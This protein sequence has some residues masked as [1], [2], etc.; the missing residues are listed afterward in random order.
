MAWLFEDLYWLLSTLISLYITLIVIWVVASWLLLF[1]VINPRNFQ[2]RNFIDIL[3]R[4]INPAL[5]PIRR[6][7]PDLGGLDLSPVILI[8]GLMFLDRML[9]RLF[10]YLAGRLG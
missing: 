3:E 8:L 4:A 10:G 9:F 2:V 1:N 7:L 6:F 5:R